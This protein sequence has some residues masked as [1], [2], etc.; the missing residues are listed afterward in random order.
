MNKNV[1]SLGVVEVVWVQWNLVDNQYKQK[2]EV[3][4]TF[5]PNKCYAYL[6]NVGPSNLMFSKT[7]NR[8]WWNNHNI[9]RSKW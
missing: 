1:P 5:T 7:Y 6:L 8:F 2:S 3:L 4:C 9:Y